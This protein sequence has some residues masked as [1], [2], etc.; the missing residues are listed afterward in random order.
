MAIKLSFCVFRYFFCR[1]DTRASHEEMHTFAN[2]LRRVYNRLRHTTDQIHA[3]TGISAPKRTLLMDLR[4][5]G[6]QTVPDLAA[7]RFISRQIIQTQVNE[8]SQAGLT[9]AKENPAHKRSKLI[10]LTAEGE[11]LVEL[12]IRN[13]SVFMDRLGWLPESDQ[14]HVCVSV[15]DAINEKLAP[16]G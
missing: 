2:S 10:A 14:L 3:H 11:R 16:R 12:M 7:V 6:A 15:M 8:L 13:E 4:R 1:M 5:Y 9:E